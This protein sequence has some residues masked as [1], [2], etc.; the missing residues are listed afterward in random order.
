[1][2]NLLLRLELAFGHPMEEYPIFEDLEKDANELYSFFSRSDKRYGN[3]DKYVK[4]QNENQII[5][6][7]ESYPD[8]NYV[9]GVTLDEGFVWS[10][11]IQQ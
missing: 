2:Y 9:P 7:K 10:S 6:S 8:I 1:M 11:D 3:L 4:T 5:D